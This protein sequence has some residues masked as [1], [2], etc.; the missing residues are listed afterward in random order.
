MIPKKKRRVLLRRFRNF[1]KEIKS[2]TS[3][4]SIYM[5]GALQLRTEAHRAK[6]FIE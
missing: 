5:L 3:M 6:Y 1:N 2:W 4:D